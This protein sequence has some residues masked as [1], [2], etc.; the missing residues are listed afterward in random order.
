MG[1]CSCRCVAVIS[2]LECCE[3][4]AMS[5]AFYCTLVSECAGRG[6]V[7]RVKVE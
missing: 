1:M 4:T 6:D 2:G 7:V 3:K 5:M